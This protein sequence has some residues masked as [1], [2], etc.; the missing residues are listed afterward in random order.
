M[1]EATR[2]E[3]SDPGKQRELTTVE[4]HI[5]WSY[6][7]LSVTRQRMKDQ[8]SGKPNRFPGGRSKWANIK[9]TRYQHGS[10]NI[11]TLDRDDRLGQ[12]G[13]RACAHCG[14]LAPEF[15]WD[16]L[17]PRSK[18]NGEYIGLNQVRSCPSCNRSRG[19]KDLM[20]WHRQKQTFPTLGVLRRYLKLCYFHA[21]QRNFLGNPARDA[22]QNGLPFDPRLLPRKFPAV[23]ALVWDHAHPDPGRFMPRTREAPPGRVQ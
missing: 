20:L 3:W 14:T 9:M 5:F 17:I 4:D 13:L 22:V 10:R 1:P 6:A 18:L 8:K 12:E 19:N 16:H 15:Q 2:W 11:S 23:E 7:M 21:K